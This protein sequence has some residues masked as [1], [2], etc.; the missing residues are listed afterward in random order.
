M[1]LVLEIWTIICL[2]NVTKCDIGEGI[3]LKCWNFDI[4]WTLGFQGLD[5]KK[6]EWLEDFLV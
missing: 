2:P 5:M 3:E 6:Y 4:E 1:E